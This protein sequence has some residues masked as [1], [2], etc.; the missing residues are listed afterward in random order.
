MALSPT[1]NNAALLQEVDEAVRKD[2][3]DTIMQRFGRW[4]V[5]G[6]IAALLLFGPGYGI[7]WLVNG[8]ENSKA[9]LYA[10]VAVSAF[11][12]TVVGVF[13]QTALVIGA[14]ERADGGAPTVRGCI[15]GAW[16]HRWRIVQWSMWTQS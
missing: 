7:T 6:V 3:L 13:F 10:G 4:I 1:N 11:G 16:D 9:A 5:A 2:R 12:A 15:R 14:N 8:H